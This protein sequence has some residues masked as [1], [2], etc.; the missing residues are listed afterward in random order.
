MPPSI[1]NILLSH[2]RHSGETTSAAAFPGLLR[3]LDSNRL[4][5][6]GYP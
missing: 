2:L 6:K 5:P 1:P 4:Q 3:G